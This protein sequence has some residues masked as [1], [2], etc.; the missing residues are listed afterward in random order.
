MNYVCLWP[1]D[2]ARHPERAEWLRMAAP[3]ARK[4]A[5]LI[6]ERGAYCYG[7]ADPQCWRRLRDELGHAALWADDAPDASRIAVW[8]RHNEEDRRRGEAMAAYEARQ[9]AEL[10]RIAAAAE[11]RYVDAAPPNYQSAPYADEL[12]AL[13]HA[14]ARSDAGLASRVVDHPPMRGVDGEQWARWVVIDDHPANR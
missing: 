7:P 2:F 10:D 6:D 11:L 8:R 5:L 14:K 3:V 4:C 13:N 1:R 9:R 12:L